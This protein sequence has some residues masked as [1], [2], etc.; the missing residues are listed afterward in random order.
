M[1][2]FGYDV[3]DYRNV[4]PM[5]G[6]LETFDRLVAEAHKRGMKIIIDYVPNHSSSEHEWFKESR[7]SRDNLKR[8]WYIWR[9]AK[10]D[11]T[12]PNNWGS[13]FGG[14]AWE[15]DETTGQYYLHLFDKG[16]P[17]LN[18]RNPEVHSEMMD[19][20]K[21]WLERGVDGFRMDVVHFILKHPDLLD[22]PLREGAVLDPDALDFF[23]YQEHRYD[24]AQPEVH[25]INR[26]FRRLLDSYGE[27]VAVGE[28]FMEDIHEW[29]KYYG[30][31]DAEEFHVPFNFRLMELKKWDAEA[32]RAD[33]DLMESAIPEH[34][35]PNYVLGNHD[36]KRL[37]TRYGARNARTAGMLLL[38]LRGTPTLYNGD[39]L[40][41]EEGKIPPHKIQDPQG[42]NL[43]AERTR[44]ACRTPMQWDASEN[45][46]FSTVEP[47]LPVSEDYQTRNV[48][49]QR[50]DPTSIYNFYRKLLWMRNGSQALTLGSY[51]ALQS[52]EG[53]F[54]YLREY[55]GETKLIALNFSDA[56]QTIDISRAGQVIMSTQMDRDD[57]LNGST[58]DLRPNEG[59]LIELQPVE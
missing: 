55:A 35:W 37:A 2:D 7:S 58:L 14:S 10:P 25:E 6:D 20:L 32:F 8:D 13:W 52:P 21:F 43:G 16:Q 36:Q 47:W 59:V 31:T 1:A 24:I 19:V 44:D 39:E 4:D 11:G 17:D 50:A 18:W 15:W 48:A 33:V 56:P 29:A 42:V 54:V 9:D 28:I 40:G 5:F 30:E 46:G 57:A 53:T 23:A 3:A 45:A 27:T 22:N 51:R 41:M 34:A 49:V 26:Q 38:T 12:P